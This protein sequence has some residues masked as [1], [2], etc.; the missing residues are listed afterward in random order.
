[1]SLVITEID[2]GASHPLDFV[3]V[4]GNPI[5]TFPPGAR[6][7][8][9]EF[10]LQVAAHNGNFG[11]FNFVDLNATVGVTNPD[12]SLSTVRLVITRRDTLP[13]GPETDIFSADQNTTASVLGVLGHNTFTINF[14]EGGI[15]ETIPES[16]YGYALYIEIS[17]F[18]IEPLNPPF[19]SG[20]ISFT[21][22]SYVRNVE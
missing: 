16:Y 14:T 8:L 19:I 6:L 4:S 18:V 11:S 21:G 13:P 22:T 12:I 3:D 7:K 1:M 5:P 10:G 15:A 17:P 9:A 20:P 2:K